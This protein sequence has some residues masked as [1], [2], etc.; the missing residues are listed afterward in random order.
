MRWKEIIN[1][2]DPF[3]GN[4]GALD[5]G[6]AF[7][8]YKE[9]KILIKQ[10]Y[11]FSSSY[12]AARIEPGF[13][14]YY[15]TSRFKRTIDKIKTFN[16][17]TNQLNMKVDPHLSGSEQL[18]P[19]VGYSWHTLVNKENGIGIFYY[20][21]RGMG[22]DQIMPFAKKK[23]DFLELK[24]LLAASGMI[25]GPEQLKKA[26]QK[27]SEARMKIIKNKG[28]GVGAVVEY[29]A[30]TARVIK[31]RPSGIL[32]LEI[33]DIQN[34]PLTLWEPKK[35]HT[36]GPL[37]GPVEKKVGDTFVERAHNIKKSQVKN[38]VR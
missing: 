25:K 26:R 17:L 35:G 8:S 20:E 3:K 12:N 13:A 1:E 38:P 37:K 24:S 5:A 36:T 6:K 33:L 30:F 7:F 34:P 21:D 19:S 10:D 2:V 11:P 29:S 27:K 32:E 18:T 28:L 9:V 15:D 22:S 16:D 31:I 23:E 14:A 4:L